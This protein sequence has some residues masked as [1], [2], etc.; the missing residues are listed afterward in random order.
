MNS[1]LQKKSSKNLGRSAPPQALL[2]EFDPER[3]DREP[4]KAYR[5]IKLMFPVFDENRFDMMAEIGKRMKQEGHHIAG[6][7]LVTLAWHKAFPGREKIGKPASQY[8]DRME[9]LLVSGSSI[10][11][12]SKALAGQVE[13]DNQN[14]LHISGPSECDD[15]ASPL[16][17]AF[18]SG[19]EGALKE[20]VNAGPTHLH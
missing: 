12:L 7:I 14:R 11:R 8:E 15:L 20:P 18:F 5:G 17:D 19:Y 3:L 16:I 1:A 2:I 10:S 6:I 4:E 9:I 13:R